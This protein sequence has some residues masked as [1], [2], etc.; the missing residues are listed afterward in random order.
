[1]ADELV[2]VK[3]ALP[4]FVDFCSELAKTSLAPILTCNPTYSSKMTMRGL[5]IREAIAKDAPI[6]VAAE[7]ETTEHQ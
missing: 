4:H 6:L 2:K 7:Q 3:I 5:L 1:L